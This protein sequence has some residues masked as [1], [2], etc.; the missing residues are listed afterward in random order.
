[1]SQQTCCRALLIP[2]IFLVLGLTAIIGVAGCGGEGQLPAKN[3]VKASGKATFDGKPIPAGGIQ[4]S[5]TASGD[6]G[7]CEIEDGLY[8]VIDNQGPVVGE[9]TMTLVGLDAVDGK[10][11]WGGSYSKV[12]VIGEDGFTEDLAVS[13]SEVQPAN[14][15]YIDVDA[16]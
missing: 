8:N 2:R 10:P 4:F 13:A 9:N 3:R 6:M 5:H 7:M 15:D 12:V 11:L 14:K 16:E 1:M